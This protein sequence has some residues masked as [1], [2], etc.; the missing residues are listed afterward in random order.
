MKK[1]YLWVG[2]V[3]VKT[4]ADLLKVE[5]ALLLYCGVEEQNRMSH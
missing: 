2:T 3:L 5:L 4:I 1:V